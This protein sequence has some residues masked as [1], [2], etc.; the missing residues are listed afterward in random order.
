[1]QIFATLRGRVMAAA[2]ILVSA[3]TVAG[4]L[5]PAASDEVRPFLRALGIISC[6]S[7]NPNLSYGHY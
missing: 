5:S 4:A 2:A 6:T 1:M 3:T 7:G